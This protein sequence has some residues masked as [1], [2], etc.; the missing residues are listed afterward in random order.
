MQTDCFRE[1]E[2]VLGSTVRIGVILLVATVTV[3]ENAL[4]VG[5]FKLRF[6]RNFLWDAI[7]AE[8]LQTNKYSKAE[9]KK[10]RPSLMSVQSDLHALMKPSTTE[11][12]GVPICFG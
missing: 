11:M 1:G 10:S 6:A 3:S 9:R 4:A 5:N 12:T 8:L 2:T 7:C